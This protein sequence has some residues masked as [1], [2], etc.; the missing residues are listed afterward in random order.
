VVGLALP[1]EQQPP[2]RLTSRNGTVDLVLPES[3][4]TGYRWELVDLPPNVRVFASE[5]HDAEP[6]LAGGQGARAFQLSVTGPG[7][8]EFTAILR[9]PWE[10]PPI[11]RRSIIVDAT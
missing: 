10:G 9:R 11:E 5:F 6:H 1:A 7:T 3:P 8:H 2:L 4:T